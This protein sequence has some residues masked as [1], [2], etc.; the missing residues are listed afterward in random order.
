MLEVG[1][2]TIHLV[3]EDQPRNPVLI[4]LTPHRFSLGLDALHGSQNSDRS[5]EHP[6]R[7]FNLRRKVHVTR[8]INNIDSDVVPKTGGSRRGDGDTA[9]LL[10]LHPIHHGSAFVHFAHLVRNSGVVQDALRG[11]RFASINVGHDADIP[12]FVERDL[13]CHKSF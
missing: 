7:P 3:D 10:L 4:R 9:L 2:H 8:R 11:G 13:S 1:P 6:E 5:V 12:C